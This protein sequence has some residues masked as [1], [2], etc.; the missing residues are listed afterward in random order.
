MDITAIRP[1]RSATLPTAPR[2]GTRWPIPLK[3]RVKDEA[4]FPAHSQPF[5][6]PGGR[7]VAL[8]G[9]RDDAMQVQLA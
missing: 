1:F 4:A 6:Q 2:T 7:L 8:V 5:Q 3:P 9:Y